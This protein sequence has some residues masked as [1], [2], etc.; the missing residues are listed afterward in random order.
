M[1]HISGNPPLSLS[2]I[3]DKIY[4]ANYAL[5]VSPELFKVAHELSNYIL[6]NVLTFS[7]AKKKLT[8]EE[9]IHMGLVKV[10]IIMN[11]RFKLTE[12]IL[13][14]NKDIYYSNGNVSD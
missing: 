13:V 5:Y 1:R 7:F 3:A 9:A 11:I 4:E 2:A 12:W 14:T 6:M 8:I 10:D